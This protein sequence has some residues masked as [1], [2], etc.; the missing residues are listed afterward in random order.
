[1]NR[2]RAPKVVIVG[3]LNIDV[4]IE[5]MEPPGIGE[6]VLGQ[7]VHYLPGGK[8]ANQA[9]AAAR[10]EADTTLIG[11]IGNDAFGT[12]IQLA[13]LE[14][15]ISTSTI[16]KV[17]EE[18]TGIASIVLSGGDNSI[19]V[20]PGA[21][22]T[23]DI[24]D[25]DQHEQLIAEADIVLMQ[26]EIP[27]ETVSYAA[28]MAKRYDKLVVVNPAPAQL[29]S[30]DLLRLIDVLTPNRSEL[31]QLAQMPEVDDEDVSDEVLAAAIMKLQGLGAGQIIVTLGA[32]GAA[33]IRPDGRL[34]KVSGLKM[35]VL[36]TTGA[37]DCFN[38]ALACVLARGQAL[39]D[40]IEF[41][42]A[43][44]ALSVTKLGAQSGM[45]TLGDVDRFMSHLD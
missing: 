18:K 3:S 40:A 41:A 29:L 44:S 16:R 15:G 38:A 25:I 19:I 31:A 10:L 17:D 22:S 7:R 14:N 24:H 26:L 45:P 28:A 43:A 11:C 35:D 33:M 37:G 42:V 6:T 9:V 21:N 34:H 1:M 20:V 27:I 4:V 30:S 39:E 12:Q 23:C 5:V 2:N 36:D 8:G 32:S 13:L